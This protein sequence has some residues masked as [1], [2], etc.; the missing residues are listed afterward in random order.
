MSGHHNLT[1]YTSNDPGAGWCKNCRDGE[2][3]TGT[4]V[5]KEGAYI[6]YS[7]SV[8]VKERCDGHLPA[9]KKEALEGAKELRKNE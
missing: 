1:I 6:C 3:I 8:P 5:F 7:N 4:K 2:Y 9:R